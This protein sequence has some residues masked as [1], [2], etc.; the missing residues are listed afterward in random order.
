MRALNWIERWA[1]RGAVLEL[2]EAAR[3]GPPGH[4]PRSPER[5]ANENPADV[6][7]LELLRE[8]FRTHGNRASPGFIA[9][10]LH[11][12]GNARM[13]VE[14][15]LLRGP[16]SLTY[17]AAFTCVHWF[18][19]I[20]LSYTVRLGR[21]V[22]LSEHGGITLNARA[23]GDDVRIHHNT[24]LGVAHRDQLADKPVVCNRVEIGAGV[25]MLGAITVADGC[26]VG[27]NAV[28]VRDLPAGVTAVGVP[29]RALQ[30]S[31]G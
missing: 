1:A 6:G 7:L 4:E 16:L 8:D 22:W 31:A 25:C 14:P 10:A 5:E 27:A 9:V 26:R 19:G 11:R 30:S 3:S 29:A 17:K 24:T 18:W 20:D 21:R 12:L 15:K 2:P 13:D 23:I 28:V